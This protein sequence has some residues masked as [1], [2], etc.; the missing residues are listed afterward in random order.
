MSTNPTIPPIV[1]RTMKAVLRSPLHELVSKTVLLI[2]FTGRK[3]G[4]TY[5]TPVSYSQ[6]DDQVIIFTHADWWKNLEECAL[7]TLRIRGRDYQGLAVP[8]VEDK[9]TVAAGLAAHLRK[10]PSDARF[11]GVKINQEGVPSAEDV[12]R[13]AQSVVMISSRFI[14]PASQD[15]WGL[16]TPGKPENLQHRNGWI[17]AIQLI[18]RAKV[19]QGGIQCLS[20]ISTTIV[21]LQPSCCSRWQPWHAADQSQEARHKNRD[22]AAPDGRL[23]TLHA[24]RR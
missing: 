1:N 10:V 7:V 17:S 24:C 6:S 23:S 3:S 12:A 22:W 18:R 19:S 4:R 14:Q 9:H 20:Q 8:I 2:S 13:A 5:T 16:C 11:Y 21:S 15:R